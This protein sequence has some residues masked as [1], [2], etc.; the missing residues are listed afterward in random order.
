MKK[1]F[2]RNG[3]FTIIETLVAVLIV[4]T[5]VT[6]AAS[7]V[8]SGLSSYIFSKDQII[9]FYL[10]QEGF[11]HIRTLRD[12]NRINNRHWLSGIA[13]TT[14]D[15]C[16]FGKYCYVT[17]VESWQPLSC[18]GGAGSCPLLRYGNN[19]G[20]GVSFYG[21]T[22]SWPETIFRREITLTRI[23]DDEVAVTVTVNWSKG[24]V[25]RQFKARENLFN[26]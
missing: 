12:G 17:N 8:Q 13:E 25:N 6:A 5:A 24:S 21:Y 18:P 26:W 14:A 4:V 7:A 19:V 22:S 11:E 3:G 23:N 1:T 20:S 10:A 9:S 2:K 15:P 16:Y